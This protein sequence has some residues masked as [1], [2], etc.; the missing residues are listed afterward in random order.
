MLSP[1]RIAT[2]GVGAQS[3]LTATQGLLA[4]PGPPPPPIFSS[5]L[6]YSPQRSPMRSPLRDVVRW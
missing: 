2:Q 5:G 1:F 4:I 6:V 3:L